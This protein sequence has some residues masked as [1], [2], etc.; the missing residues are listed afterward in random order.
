[1]EQTKQEQKV[2]VNPADYMRINTG[3]G[4]TG[5]AYSFV[6][7]DNPIP[8]GKSELLLQWAKENGVPEVNWGDSRDKNKS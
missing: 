7:M 2:N 4:K 6:T 1:M 8:R 3:I 5:K